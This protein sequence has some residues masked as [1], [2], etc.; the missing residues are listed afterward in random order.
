LAWAEAGAIFAYMR[1][2][3]EALLGEN[4]IV[5]A[6]NDVVSDARMARLLLEDRLEYFAALALVGK[7]LVG[8]RR[9]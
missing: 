2:R 7:G 3:T 8:F 4:G 5:V 6:M 1:R 9:G